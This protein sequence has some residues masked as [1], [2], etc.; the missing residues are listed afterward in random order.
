MFRTGAFPALLLIYVVGCSTK[1]GVRVNPLSV[2]F[3]VVGNAVQGIGNA[4]DDAVFVA[5]KV[6]ETKTNFLTGLDPEQSRYLETHAIAIER[7]YIDAST[8]P[9]NPQYYFH[10]DRYRSLIL[11]I[12]HLTGHQYQWFLS[13]EVDTLFLAEPN[14]VL[15]INPSLLGENSGEDGIL[16]AGVREAAHHVLGQLTQKGGAIRWDAPK[17]NWCTDEYALAADRQAAAF[18][19]ADGV[20]NHL[21]LVGADLAAKR[22]LV[23]PLSPP[24]RRMEVVRAQLAEGLSR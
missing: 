4:F 17:E 14:G 19:Q 3:H 24:E 9:R 5:P 18:L 1:S 11:Q 22:K 8:A 23:K 10:F 2:P 13:S 21:I 20:P 16:F 7:T 6:Q 15:I 12:E